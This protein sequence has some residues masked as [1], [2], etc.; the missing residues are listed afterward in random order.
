MVC[1]FLKKV[2]NVLNL[3][4]YL[5]QCHRSQFTIS[6][7]FVQ[8]YLTQIVTQKLWIIFDFSRLLMSLTPNSKIQRVF[9]MYMY[10]NQ[11]CKFTSSQILM[12]S[13]N[14]FS[15]FSSVLVDLRQRFLEQ[16]FIYIFLSICV[17][18]VL[19]CRVV[20]LAICSHCF[21]AFNFL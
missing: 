15:I 8:I 18:V 19:N 13:N 12:K 3:I 10:F 1:W 5:V 7:M 21:V 17:Y 20:N 16:V 11:Q 4:K 2:S 6:L 9:R 14:F